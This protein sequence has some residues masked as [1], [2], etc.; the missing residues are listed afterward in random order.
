[1]VLEEGEFIRTRVMILISYMKIKILYFTSPLHERKTFELRGCT[2]T[3]PP[4][5]G[6]F[7]NIRITMMSFHFLLLLFFFL[8]YVGCSGQLTRTTTIPHGRLDIL[9]AQEQVR[10]RGITG[11]HIKGRTRNGNGTSHAI[12][13]SR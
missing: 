12:D 13:H 2:R 3:Q 8:I 7:L 1:M 6:R 11:L 4:R 9:Q 10:H 5:T